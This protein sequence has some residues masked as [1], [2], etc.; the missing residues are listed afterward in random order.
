MLLFELMLG[1]YFKRLDYTGFATPS[2]Q[3]GKTTSSHQSKKIQKISGDNRE[4]IY[5][6]AIAV[7]FIIFAV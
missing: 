4:I 7:I 5:Y 2:H 3:V 6:F 1:H